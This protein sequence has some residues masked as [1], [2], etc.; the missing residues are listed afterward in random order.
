M[1]EFDNN[2]E[3]VENKAAKYRLDKKMLSRAGLALL[4]VVFIDLALEIGASVIFSTFLPNVYKSVYFSACAKIVCN[5]LIAIPIGILILRTMIKP[6]EERENKKLG[7]GALALWVCVAIAA[8]IIG[9]RIGSAVNSL[10]ESAIGRGS[11]SELDTI[12]N[13]FPLWLTFVLMVVAAPIAEELLFRRG[14]TEALRPWGW[15]LAVL[16]SGVLFGVYHGNLEQF[17]YTSFLGILFGYVYLYTG[18]V[19]YTVFLHMAVNLISGFIPAVINRFSYTAADAERFN[20]AIEAYSSAAASAAS[21][22]EIPVELMQEFFGAMAKILPSMALSMLYNGLVFGLAIAG[23]IVAIL[24]YRKVNLKAAERK[25][26]REYLGDTVF[27]APGVLAFIVVML[28]MMARGI[29]FA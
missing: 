11:H 14:L 5:Y 21:P 18:K 12:V 17:F 4:A 15:K 27:L 22:E 6:I 10:I 26:E 2:F 19:R 29:V 9:S 28:V 7:A 16:L 24:T 13:M 25:I 20:A 23:V 3:T 1:S 8:M